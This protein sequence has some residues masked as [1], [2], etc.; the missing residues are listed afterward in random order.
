MFDSLISD[1]H[2]KTNMKLAL[3]IASQ[4]DIC[5]SRKI[6][7]VITDI[8][9]VILSV[10]INGP[11]RKT[12]HCDTED[13]IAEILWDKLSE[14]DKGKLKAIAKERTNT[15]EAQF[16][17]L[18]SNICKLGPA[19]GDFSPTAHTVG[20]LLDGCKMCPRKMLG[21]KSGEN[22]DW[23]S[24]SH[25]ESNSIINAKCSLEGGFLF[26]SCENLSCMKCTGDI[27]NAGI[28]EVH[29]VAGPEY[30][31]GCIKL[32]QRAGIKVY[33]YAM[34]WINEAHEGKETVPNFR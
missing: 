10:G 25:S 2:I 11:P 8:N 18:A 3:Y 4:N 1:K 13:Y 14:D 6:G 22:S 32:Y 31:S 28:K 27:I 24:C 7:T 26:C 16:E 29:F 30:H 20:R 19:F 12:P 33:C 21:S 15:S 17:N 23:C 5:F 9:S 34:E